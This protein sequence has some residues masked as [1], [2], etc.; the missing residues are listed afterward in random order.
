MRITSEFRNF[1]ENYIISRAEK[2]EERVIISS[3][4]SSELEIVELSESQKRAIDD[5]YV[6]NY[7]RKIPYTWHQYYTSFTGRFDVRYFPERMYIP[8]FERYV[9]PPAYANVFGNKNLLPTIAKAAGVKYAET[10]LISSD[11]IFC[12]EELNVLTE[13]EAV[14]YLADYGPLY[15]KKSIDSSGGVAC[16]KVDFKNGFD[17]T[18]GKSIKDYFTS[19]GENFIAQR[20]IKQHPQLAAFESGSAATFRVITYIWNGQIYS[21]PLTLR[22]GRAGTCVA[23][24]A[25][26]I[27]V[28]DDG[29]IHPDGYSKR[30]DRY[31]EHPDSHLKFENCCIPDA[32]KLI[33]AAK[34]IHAV[35]PQLG[36][37]HWD[38]AIDEKGEPVVIEANTKI[39]SIWLPEVVHGKGPFGENTASILRWMRFMEN[40]KIDDRYK[41]HP[42]YTSLE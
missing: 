9:N 14:K 37:I 20:E 13:D 28:D 32:S 33:D 41:Y 34:L 24:A 2:K 17:A 38:F 12:D 16:F 25:V 36:I 31:V 4:R 10:I 5:F 26:I 29:I 30:G 22:I 23:N 40:V 8:R 39:G 21:C 3:E 1:K 27:A 11:N 42:G 6:E 15:I 7:G 18:T 19:L 35:V